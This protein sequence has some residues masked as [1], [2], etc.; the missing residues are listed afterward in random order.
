MKKYAQCVDIER[1]LFNFPDHDDFAHYPVLENA[2]SPMG[3]LA[4]FIWI[5]RMLEWIEKTGAPIFTPHTGLSTARPED[6]VFTLLNTVIP[7]AHVQIHFPPPACRNGGSGFFFCPEQRHAGQHNSGW[8]S[9]P[10]R[11]R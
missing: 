3:N 7:P 1:F 10:P 5:P 2:P 4:S 6:F 11:F 8:R 9:A